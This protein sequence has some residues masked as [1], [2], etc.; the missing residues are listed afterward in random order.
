LKIFKDKAAERLKNKYQL[1]VINHKKRGDKGKK[2]TT[3]Q[4][5]SLLNSGTS[6]FVPQENSE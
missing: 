1:S 4:K 5:K 6:P 2:G 3:S